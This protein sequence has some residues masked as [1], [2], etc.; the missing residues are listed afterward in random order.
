MDHCLGFLN[1][2]LTTVFFLRIISLQ[3]VDQLFGFNLPMDINHLQA[4][5]SVVFHTLDAYLLKLLDQLGIIHI[6][7]LVYFSGMY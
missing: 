2:H 5:L 6:T 1:I 4:L 3:T 7:L